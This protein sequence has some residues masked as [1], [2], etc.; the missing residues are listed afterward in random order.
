MQNKRYSKQRE[1]I[2]QYLA[3]TDRHPTAE[4]VYAAVRKQ[5]PNIGIATVYRNLNQLSECGDIRK[6]ECGS[7]DRF[8]YRTGDHG[9]FTCTSCG[10]VYDVFA[11]TAELK[12]EAEQ[13]VGRVDFCELMFYGVCRACLDKQGEASE[14][15]R[16]ITA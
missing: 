16:S 8:D 15:E 14:T 3:G 9:H 11:D 5:Y 1:A 7:S 13:S 6:I 4:E 2:I 10:R 12:A